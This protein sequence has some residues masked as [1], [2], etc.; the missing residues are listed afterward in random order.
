MAVRDAGDYGF[1]LSFE[2]A[3]RKGRRENWN[4]RDIAALLKCT[5]AEVARVPVE[6]VV[7]K[8]DD[9]VFRP[10]AEAGG[11]I[12]EYKADGRAKTQAVPRLVG[13][14]L[15]AQNEALKE[16]WRE[17]AALKTQRKEQE[18]ERP[19]GT[20]GDGAGARRPDP[21]LGRA[22]YSKGKKKAGAKA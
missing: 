15:E 21:R 2:D 13:E 12:V 16:L 18:V 19:G 14:I 5:E 22:G 8:L 7:M 10:D 4:D 17:V 11:M 1:G 20:D 9:L 6:K 3:V